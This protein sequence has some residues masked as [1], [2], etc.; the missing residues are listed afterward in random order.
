MDDYSDSEYFGN[1]SATFG[2]RVYAAR[3]TIGLSQADLAKRLGIKRKTMRAWEEDLAEPRANKLQMLAG[4][5]N[6]SVMWLLTGEGDGISAPSEDVDLPG[7]ASA[8]LADMRMTKVELQR[9][10]ENMSKLE[11]RMAKLAGVS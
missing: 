8:I 5:L 3:E 10:S 6:V 4:V 2:D 1:E 9:L 11:R 7:D